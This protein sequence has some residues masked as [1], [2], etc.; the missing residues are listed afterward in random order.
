MTVAGPD[1]CRG[2]ILAVQVEMG[3]GS[4]HRL[5]S[6]PSGW[7][8][9]A[10]PVAWDHF[11]HGETFDATLPMDW[12]PSGTSPGVPSWA[13][14]RTLAP[15]AT[16]P[17]GM[18][19]LAPDGSAI[20]LGELK[21]ATAPP[22][23]VTGEFAALSVT[24]VH[25]SDVGSAAF[26]FDFGQNMAGMVR[27]SLPPAN[28]IPAGTAL[29][30]EHGEILQGHDVDTE[31]MCALCPKCKSCDNSGGGLG[32]VGPCDSRGIGAVCNTYCGTPAQLGG[33]DNHS[34][35]HEPCFP[36]QSYTPG[37]PHTCASHACPHETADRYIGD[38]NNANQTN[39]YIVAADAAG[40]RYT[41]YFAAAGFRYAQLSGLPPG[42]MPAASWLTALRMHTAVPNAS[43]LR[44]QPTVGSALGTRDVLGKLHA[45]TR[46]SQTS[47]L[48]S[49]PT[50]CPQRERRGWTG[51]AQA[52]S[53][54]ASTNFDMQAFYE[55][56]VGTIRDDQRR[57]DANHA[58]DTGAIADVVPYDGIG[59]NPGCPV[60]QV[61]YIVISHALWKHYGEAALPT[62]RDHYG[63]LLELMGWFDRHADPA[64]GL[65]VTSCYGDWMGF[66]IDT[67]NSRS[68]ALTPRA[69]V[70]AFYHVRASQLL[71]EVA[72][73]LGNATEA[74]RHA[75]NFEQGQGAYHA[76]FYSA[77]AGG[78][79]PCDPA[80]TTCAGTSFNGSQTS[81]AMALVLGAPPDDATAHR[82]AANLAAD[83]VAFGNRTTAGVIGMAWVFAQLDRYGYGA[84]A[85]A[86]LLN[87]AYPSLG[88][89][90]HQNMTT[91]CENWS[92]TF[93]SAGGGSQNHIML[94]GF[95]T[96]LTSA[97]GGLAA[98][99]NGST[100]G[101]RHV[102][103]RVTPAAIV[104]VG[105]ARYT[106]AT[107]LGEVSLAWHYDA[108][109][110]T[111]VKE[112]GVP[113]GARLTLHM[114]VTLP[115]GARL[116][117][118]SEGG[119]PLWSRHTAGAAPPLPAGVA[120]VGL[121]AEA[122]AVLTE[123]TSGRYTVA[124]TYE[125]GSASAGVPPGV[126]SSLQ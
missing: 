12:L 57:Y 43:E 91:L 35:R 2:L 103:A 114:P 96:F 122:E 74:A 86:T 63:G 81:N 3:D 25:A 48:W 76:R 22:V 53:D 84:E 14:A 10:G 11:F 50:D 116:A 4:V 95:D 119:A 90:A 64:D 27:L 26:I 94:G 62:L 7:Q 87:D 49:V 23:R 32:S 66:N 69:A 60:W 113:V 61:A 112:V 107:R 97:V 71:S 34:L 101:W 42:V 31:Q 110:G 20:A 78:Y 68:S 123:L 28:G 46:A 40:E 1:G 89:M 106:Q 111:L 16:A 29:R 47:N 19:V 51:D 72:A 92:C 100:G 54:E 108:R 126:P 80:A 5:E 93:H 13:P 17:T 102:V 45:M 36:H 67:G 52:S 82:V 77:A 8:A 33:V 6:A 9:R 109:A 41:P 38:F 18:Q 124:A 39:V 88:H 65:L 105:G 79:S 104:G 118:L 73:A 30:I 21:P 70:T 120:A 24:A 117:T 121:R 85:L 99:V 58:D 115:G 56:Y 75:A 15:V 59:G 83:V 44:L 98:V 55:Q 125:G 37:Y